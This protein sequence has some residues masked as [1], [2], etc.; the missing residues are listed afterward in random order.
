MK[1]IIAFFLAPFSYHIVQVQ[2]LET[3]SE[4]IFA[5]NEH[6]TNAP[7]I[8]DEATLLLFLQKY[9]GQKHAVNYWLAYF[10][11]NLSGAMNPAVWLKR[12]AHLKRE[13]IRSMNQILRP[14]ATST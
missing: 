9:K 6:L 1:V 3:H 10:Q 12:C 7:G 14:T 13:L 4:A 11:Y 8:H 2:F 5:W